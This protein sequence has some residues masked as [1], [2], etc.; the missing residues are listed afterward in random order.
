MQRTTKVFKRVFFSAT[1]EEFFANA[2]F[3]K[4]LFSQRTGIVRNRADTAS[5]TNHFG[6]IVC[7]FDTTHL[8]TDRKATA[9]KGSYVYRP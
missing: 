7:K 8:R 6:H 4:N 2:P 5:K 9:N 3:L 1:Q